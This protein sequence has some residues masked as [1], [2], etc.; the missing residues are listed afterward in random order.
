MC[1]I[2]WGF[3]GEGNNRIFRENELNPFDAWSLARFHVSLWASVKKLL[4][5]YPLSF[6]LLDK[7]PFF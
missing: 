1:A 4:C 7:I 3:G 5:N 6:I 2:V